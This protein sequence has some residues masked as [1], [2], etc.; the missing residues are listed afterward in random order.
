MNSNVFK[1]TLLLTSLTLLLVWIGGALGGRSG[2]MFALVFAALMNL[3][4]Y[5]FSDKM[6]LAMYGARPLSQEDAPD[7]YAI[8]ARLAEK[9]GMPMPRIYRIPTQTPNAFAT[10]RNPSHAVVA[11]TDGILGLLTEEELE[12]VL[13][14]ELSHVEHRDIL[15]SSIAATI[16]GAIGMLASMARWSL[17]MG[18]GRDSDED[19]NPLGLLIMAIVAP[20]AATLVQ[21]AVS[22]SR[23]FHADETGARLCG[24]PRYLASALA[25]LEAGAMRM[26]MRGVNPATA[27]LFIVNPLRGSSL[28]NLFSTHPPTAERIARLERMSA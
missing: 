4:S 8:V 24:H 18:G 12:G 19:R 20:L 9:G 5:W 26:P 11:V 1:T 23:E 21:L 14:H 3:G 2:M 7:L 17:F 15:I 22:R 27:H 28:A 10:G 25:K 16:A 6:V 13:A